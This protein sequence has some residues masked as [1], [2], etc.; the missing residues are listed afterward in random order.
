MH[1]GEV[2]TVSKTLL[3]ADL[4]TTIEG[5]RKIHGLRDLERQG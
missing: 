2:Q 1:I 3:D 5:K 4:A